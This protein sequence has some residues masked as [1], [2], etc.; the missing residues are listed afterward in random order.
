MIDPPPNSLP[1]CH[2]L[3]SP[4]RLPFLGHFRLRVQGSDCQLDLCGRIGNNRPP[5]DAW[6]LSAG[7]R[8]A[9]SQANGDDGPSLMRHCWE[10]VLTLPRKE[11]GPDNGMDLALLLVATD[12]N[13]LYLS[14]VGLAG[15]WRQTGHEL[16]EIANPMTVE[17]QHPGIPKLPPKVLK[18]SA[19]KARFFASPLGQAL[20]N[21]TLP[22]L[23]TAAG[24][25]Q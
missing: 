13:G 11:F 22:E 15:I 25:D 14:G 8:Q 19:G 20:A 16:Q 1:N 5:A 12:P 10:Q 21:P 9:L 7:V 24:F 17:T 18:L 2:F 4:G 3:G 23:M 6:R